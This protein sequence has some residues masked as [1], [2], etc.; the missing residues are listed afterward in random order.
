[1]AEFYSATV[2]SS[3]RFR[4]YFVSGIHKGRLGENAPLRKKHGA[5]RA[6]GV[7]KPLGRKREIRQANPAG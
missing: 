4:G 2:R 3:D 1:M 5:V 7:R 6:N